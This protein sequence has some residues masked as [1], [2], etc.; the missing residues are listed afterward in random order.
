MV[1]LVGF[2][3]SPLCTLLCLLLRSRLGGRG[4]DLFLARRGTS[5]DHGSEVRLVVL[6]CDGECG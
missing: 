3:R 2:L 1:L 4:R 5:L 6:K